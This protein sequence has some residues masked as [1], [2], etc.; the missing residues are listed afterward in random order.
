M[1]KLWVLSREFAKLIE[2][3]HVFICIIWLCQLGTSRLLWIIWFF[4]IF[5]STN[6]GNRLCFPF[7]ISNSINISRIFSS[8]APFYKNLYSPIWPSSEGFLLALNTNCLVT[9]EHKHALGR[10][11]KSPVSLETR[12][13]LDHSGVLSG[14]SF[15]QTVF[16]PCPRLVSP[17]PWAWVLCILGCQE[18]GW[19]PQPPAAVVNAPSL[20]QARSAVLV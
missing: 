2:L 17:W 10:W 13:I 4:C 1:V 3:V 6:N 14:V 12:T 19:E 7:D 20:L 18:M 15:E 5:A 11:I 8:W 16:Q 9:P